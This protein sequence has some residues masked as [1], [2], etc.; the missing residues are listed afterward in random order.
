MLVEC[1]WRSRSGCETSEAMD[2]TYQ[3]WPQQATSVSADFY[4]YRMQAVVHFWQ[5]NA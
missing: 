4:E 2:G 3:Q 5:K 1:S